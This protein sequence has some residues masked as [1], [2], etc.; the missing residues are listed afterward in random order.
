MRYGKNNGVVCTNDRFGYQVRG[1]CS[2]AGPYGH[3]LFNITKEESKQITDLI[4]EGDL[5]TK[6]GW[7][8]FSMHPTMTNEEIYGFT[9]AIKQ[10]V[11]NREKWQ[12]DYVYDPKSN[13]YFYVHH[14]KNE[15]ES[16][17]RM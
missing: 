6:P 1:G 15:M 9:Q 10:I 16:L 11:E 7:I 2:C 5:S 8:R 14:R 12:Q 4:D 17:F 3:Y 13:D